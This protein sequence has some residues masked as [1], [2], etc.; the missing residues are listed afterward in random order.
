MDAKEED[1]VGLCPRDRDKDTSPPWSR[2]WIIII[3]IKGLSPSPGSAGGGEM[4]PE[5][6]WEML[7]TSDWIGLVELGRARTVELIPRSVRLQ[8][9]LILDPE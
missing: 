7:I 3:I 2:R 6:R 5:W 1:L 8:I 4:C 9:P